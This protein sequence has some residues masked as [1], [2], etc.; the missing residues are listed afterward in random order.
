MVGAMRRTAIS[1]SSWFICLII[2]IIVFGCAGESENDHDVMMAPAD[3]L[4]GDYDISAWRRANIY[5]EANDYD[6]LNEIVGS[7]AEE[8]MDEGFVSAVFQTYEECIDDACSLVRIHLNVYDQGS[9]ESARAVY[10]RVSTGIDIPWDG[11][12]TEARIDE[13]D[14]HSYTVEFWQQNFFIQVSIEEKTDESLNVV[15]L[16]ASHVSSE[17]R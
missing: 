16:F 13:S 5:S 4:P 10:E 8:I 17:I 1:E 14:L 12:G 2:L 7:K 3:L 11:A 6:S 15:K 9:N